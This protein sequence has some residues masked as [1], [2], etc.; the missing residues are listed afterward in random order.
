M[1]MLRTNI[2]IINNNNKNNKSTRTI[3]TG[4]QIYAHKNI[5][6]QTY[7]VSKEL[8]KEQYVNNKENLLLC[9]TK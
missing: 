3:H 2:I 1:P 5:D 8:S 7:S 6:G 9:L 4:L